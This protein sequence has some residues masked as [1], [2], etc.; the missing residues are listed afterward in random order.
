MPYRLISFLSCPWS[1]LFLLALWM[2]NLDSCN[3]AIS[4]ILAV[5]HAQTV[6]TLGDKFTNEW[7]IFEE[8]I[9]LLCWWQLFKLKEKPNPL[10]YCLLLLGR[11]K[12]EH[13]WEISR[14]FHFFWFFLPFWINWMIF[15]FI[16]LL[17]SSPS[18]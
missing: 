12:K 10:L 6:E 9:G 14:I 1:C 18:F 7:I 5:W 4:Q 8:R 15:F 3:S 2:L 11:K 16:H 13:G 17:H